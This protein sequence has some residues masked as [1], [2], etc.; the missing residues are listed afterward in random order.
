MSGSVD[1]RR[2]TD[3]TLARPAVVKVEGVERPSFKVGDRVTF[4][5][6]VGVTPNINGEA[7]TLTEVTG[8][9]E[10]SCSL[11]EK[12]VSGKVS[13]IVM[14]ADP[15]TLVEQIR[16]HEGWRPGIADVLHYD[17]LCVEAKGDKPS[18]SFF[19]PRDVYVSHMKWTHVS[20]L[21]RCRA[22]ASVGDSKFGCGTETAEG[23]DSERI[24]VVRADAFSLGVSRL[25]AIVAPNSRMRGI[26]V[27]S[28]NGYD[29]GEVTKLSPTMTWNTYETIPAGTRPSW[30]ASV[31]PDLR[32]STVER[33]V[34]LFM[35]ADKYQVW[36]NEDLADSSES[37]NSGRA[38][39]NLEVGTVTSLS[40][41]ATLALRSY[42]DH[43]EEVRNLGGA[44]ALQFES[45]LAGNTR[46]I[47]IVMFE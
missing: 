36:Y 47:I 44:D 26:T 28:S 13:G 38:C 35:K 37:D 41:E 34:P 6:V 19:I 14:L 29:L 39:Y 32:T 8:T 2:R 21:I 4:R 5:G 45:N 24:V 10:L 17:N 43:E 40:G 46:S 20:G 11:G 18:A 33:R 1:C 42:G 23:P 31:R 30:H 16:M 27:D 12:K 15:G 25:E 7:C 9:Q 22:D 3:I